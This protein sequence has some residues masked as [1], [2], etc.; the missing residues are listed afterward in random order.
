MS[1]MDPTKYMERTHVLA[2]DTQFMPL[3]DTRHVIHDVFD[4]TMR[5]QAKYQMILQ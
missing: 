5:K 1:S 3:I 4:T 2:N